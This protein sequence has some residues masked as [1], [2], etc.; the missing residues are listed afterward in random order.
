MKQQVK[1]YTPKLFQKYNFNKEFLIL[2]KV[3]RKMVRQD[4]DAVFAVTGKEGSSKST[5]INQIGFKVDKSYDLVRNVLYSP[6]RKELKDKV[7]NLPR[8]SLINGDEA[9]KILYKLQW[10]SPMQIFMNK[11]YRICRQ[12]NKI[13]GLAMPRFFEF[14]EGFRNHRIEIWI[15]L[16]ERGCGAVFM[17]DWS[18]WAKD[19]WWFQENQKLID[20]QR[21]ALGKK[22]FDFTAKDKIKVFKKSRNFWGII[23][24]PDL[25]E[26]LRIR[27]KELAG[28]Q[29]YEGLEE[30]YQS[31]MKFTKYTKFYHRT[32]KHAIIELRQ[33]DPNLSQ[34]DIARKLKVSQNLI[35]KILK[36]DSDDD[37]VI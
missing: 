37:T 2:C 27:Y 13:T 4:W 14:N 20:K 29:K 21:K 17:K 36:A 19:P 24:F 33:N 3:L 26:P 12:E 34:R 11:L 28:K 25:P 10:H 23:T 5:C 31:G 6:T 9:I 16:I 18:P 30:D 1:I 35:Q 7:L 15:H 22:L 8:F 32:L